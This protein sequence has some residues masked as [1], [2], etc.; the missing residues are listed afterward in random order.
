VAMP[1]LTCAQRR[2]RWLP[3]ALSEEN[4]EKEAW[5]A[6]D[7]A[8]ASATGSGGGGSAE[9]TMAVGD[10]VATRTGREGKPCRLS[11]GGG[12]DGRERWCAE[13]RGEKEKGDDG[14]W[15]SATQVW[16]K[17]KIDGIAGAGDE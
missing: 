2:T 17:G 16:G 1:R 13:G 10:V 11:G 8:A 9:I 7:A 4:D 14:R 5:R 12:G 15:A 6:P 3:H